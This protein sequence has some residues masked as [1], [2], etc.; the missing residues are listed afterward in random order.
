[1]RHITDR[2][3]PR[4]PSGL[5]GLGRNR[6]DRAVRQRT[7]G[8]RSFNNLVIGP[9]Q[10]ARSLPLNGGAVSPSISS[11]M[12]P[13]VRSVTCRPFS[14]SASSARRRSV[15]LLLRA[16]ASSRFSLMSLPAGV[17]VS[18]R[19]HLRRDVR[20]RSSA[21]LYPSPSLPRVVVGIP[22][23]QRLAGRAEPSVSGGCRSRLGRPAGAAPRRPGGDAGTAT[24]VAVPVEVHRH[25]CIRHGDGRGSQHRQLDVPPLDRPV[26][27]VAGDR[28]FQHQQPFFRRPS[29][30]RPAA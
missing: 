1:M 11:I 16:A 25:P 2:H 18:R 27:F 17:L 14:V 9:N 22:G 6:E 19:A 23:R 10:Y 8:R 30:R 26:A 21:G 7:K 12:P 28:R 3:Q 15:V 13:S 20:V 24:K 29:S 5:F 4:P